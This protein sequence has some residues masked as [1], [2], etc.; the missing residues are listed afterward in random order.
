MGAF[1]RALRVDPAYATAWTLLGHEYVEMRNLPAAC[2]A[3]RRATEG[4]AR[5]YR[6]LAAALHAGAAVRSARKDGGPVTVRIDPVVL[7]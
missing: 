1:R 7:G 2:E 3:Y 6:A 5:D 4:D